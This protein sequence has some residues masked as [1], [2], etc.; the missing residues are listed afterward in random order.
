MREVD[1]AWVLIWGFESIYVIFLFRRAWQCLRTGRAWDE[2]ISTS[3][4]AK[5]G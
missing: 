5:N 4:E 1:W 2:F 3:E